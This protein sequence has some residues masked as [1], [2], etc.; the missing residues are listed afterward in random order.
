MTEKARRAVRAGL[1]YLTVSFLVVGLWATL[2][3]RGF[4]DGFPG[5]GRH[6]VAG[7]GP[8]NAHLVGDAGVGFLAV[9]IVLLLATMWMDARL[10]QAAAIA[11]AVHGAPHLLFHLRHPNE[12]LGSVDRWLSSGG[13]AFGV[14]V[15]LVV[16]VVTSRSPDKAAAHTGG[17][18]S[19]PSDPQLQT[20][21]NERTS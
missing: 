7:D 20:P 18:R 6:W 11:V 14:L 5:G 13:L 9:G 8:Y 12:S 19:E 21:A 1:L 15:A 4:Y 16:L 3:P 17:S 2:D 10:I